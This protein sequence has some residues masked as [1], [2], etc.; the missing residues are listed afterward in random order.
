MSDGVQPPL[1]CVCG[2][3]L[4]STPT[5]IEPCAVCMLRARQEGRIDDGERWIA[6]MKGVVEKEEAKP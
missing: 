3:P 5:G 2:L 6:A 4:T 1:Q